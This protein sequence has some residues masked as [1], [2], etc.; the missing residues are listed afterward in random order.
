MIVEFPEGGG[1]QLLLAFFKLELIKHSVPS[2]GKLLGKNDVK[3]R[4]SQRTQ[5]TF[6]LWIIDVGRK[7]DCNFP[8]S[9]G[10]AAY[11]QVIINLNTQRC[12][13]GKVV[14]KEL[15]FFGRERQD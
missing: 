14:E 1:G 11:S 12:D 8:L 3:T 7:L 15:G 4:G 13:V 6:L 5:I 9:K 10:G 2:S